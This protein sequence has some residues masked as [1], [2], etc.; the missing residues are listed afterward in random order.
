LKAIV[1]NTAQSSLS[2]NYCLRVTAEGANQNAW[3][4]FF[5]TEFIL[6]LY[7][8]K[9]VFSLLLCIISKMPT[10]KCIAFLFAMVIVQDYQLKANE[11]HFC[12]FQGN[13]KAGAENCKGDIPWERKSF[14]WRT[15]DLGNTIGVRG[16]FT[17]YLRIINN[18][19]LRK[20][21]ERFSTTFLQDWFL[22]P[23]TWPSCITRVKISQLVNRKCF[24]ACSQL[25]T[26][27]YITCCC[28][29]VTRLMRPTDSE[30]VVQ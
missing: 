23:S 20:L 1:Y 13:I 26:N 6:I 8:L 4:P 18:I 3:K 9:V 15:K 10:L 5:N 12:P 17:L 29:L 30:Q 16:N 7:C 24:T 19:N 21:D 27:L 14:L 11:N 25:L 2:S 22:L 28:H